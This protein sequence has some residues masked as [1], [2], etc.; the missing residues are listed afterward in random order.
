MGTNYSNC[1]VRC[2]SQET[3]VEALRGLLTEPAYVSRAV[4]DWVSVYPE[5]K[6]LDED[7][8]AKRLSAGL[9]CGVFFW[10]VYDSDAFL[11]SF[12]R[13]GRLVDQ[14]NS[15]PDGY[16]V[17]SEAK[18]ARVRGKPAA[19][20]PF[21]RPGVGLAQ[22]QDVL[23]PPPLRH[24]RFLS[25]DY[26][27][28]ALAELLGIAAE[29]KRCSYRDIVEAGGHYARRDFI[30]LGPEMLLPKNLVK[31]LWE[32]PMQVEDIKAA[33]DAGAN[34]NERTDDGETYL[35]LAAFNC[36]ST[37]VRVLLEAGA[38]INA[39][40]TKRNEHGWEDRG[41]S[42]LMAAVQGGP[43]VEYG[44]EAA[45]TAPQIE[46]VRLLIE[47]GVKVNAASET[48]Q[49]ALK[50]A[51]EKLDY[52]SSRKGDRFHSKEILAECV[53]RNTRLLEMLRAAGATE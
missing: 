18:K 8:L 32:L 39:V 41:I 30:F 46:T 31:K 9:N 29:L 40:T 51:E 12:Y 21:C 43:N 48:G 33:V 23:H 36:A 5:G 4:G 7:N 53:A 37:V 15:N 17:I 13:N 34:V 20:V 24:D 25:A 19:L 28:G 35:L 26:Q 42:V 6:R 27:A 44:D 49:T 52:F 10:A 3:V 45:N 11:Y 22:V 14:F 1:Q 38:D 2:D 47:A 16:E 50:E